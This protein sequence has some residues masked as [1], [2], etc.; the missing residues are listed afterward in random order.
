MDFD[1][2]VQGLNP[3]QALVGYCTNSRLFFVGPN[4]N[5]QYYHPSVYLR[6]YLPRAYLKAIILFGLGIQ[7]VGRCQLASSLWVVFC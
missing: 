1:I 7:K 4:P 5:R 6:A 3:G 2:A